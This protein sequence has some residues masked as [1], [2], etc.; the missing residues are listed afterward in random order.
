MDPHRRSRHLACWLAVAAVFLALGC[1]RWE[2]APVPMRSLPLSRWARPAN[3]LV[4]LLPGRGGRPED[5]ALARFPELA[6]EAGVR[7]DFV[8][9]DVRLAY[10]LRQGVVERLHD[11]VIAPARARGYEQVWLVGVSL[12][13]AAALLYVQQHPADVSGLLLIAPYLGEPAMAREVAAAGG[14]ERWTPPAVPPRDDFARPLWAE[15]KHCIPGGDRPL[16]LYL[17]FGD[18]DRFVVP[19]GLLAAALS[20]DHVFRPAG[21]HDWTTW[22]QVWKMFLASGALPHRGG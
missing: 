8:A 4:V 10:F 11:D 15:L 6:A 7:A 2:A 21:H 9:A 12:G 5:F 16:P 20:P 3:C 17:G 22:T 13:G 18:R 1:A 19:D 14:L